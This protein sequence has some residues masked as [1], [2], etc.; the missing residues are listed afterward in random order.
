MASFIDLNV[1]VA[2]GDEVI[3][4]EELFELADLKVPLVRFRGHWV[5]I[6]ADKIRAVADFSRNRNQTTLRE[7]IRIEPGACQQYDWWWN[8]AVENQ[9][10]DRG[11][12]IGQPRDVHVHKMIWAGTLEDRI[13]LVIEAEQATMDLVVGA[14]LER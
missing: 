14:T 9:A 10:T 3:E 2:M 13:A 5:E 7:V 11:F 1:E 8:R 6:N 12:R 4:P